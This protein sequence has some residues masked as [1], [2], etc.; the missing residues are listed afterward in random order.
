M[1]LSEVTELL[2]LED[3][4]SFSCFNRFDPKSLFV[5][6]D[7]AGV[8]LAGFGVGELIVSCGLPVGIGF[9]GILVGVGVD[10]GFLVGVGVDAGLL[11]RVGIEIVLVLLLVTCLTPKT[12]LLA[13]SILAACTCPLLNTTSFLWYISARRITSNATISAIKMCFLGEDNKYFKL[14]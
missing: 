9:V 1:L 4:N 14:A 5:G 2:P 7:F 11:V 10:D 12:F 3:L 6:S 8:G 13:L